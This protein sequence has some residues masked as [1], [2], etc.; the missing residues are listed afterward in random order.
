M[1]EHLSMEIDTEYDLWLAE[2]LMTKKPLF[3]NE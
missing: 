3:R 2:E 1:P